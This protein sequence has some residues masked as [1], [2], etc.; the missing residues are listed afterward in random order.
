MT[1]VRVN[2]HKGVVIQAL[3]AGMFRSVGSEQQH[4]WR[5]NEAHGCDRFRTVALD[6]GC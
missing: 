4:W 6:P 1:A 5:W 2:D 3:R